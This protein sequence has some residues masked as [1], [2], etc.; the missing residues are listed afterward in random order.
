MPPAPSGRSARCSSI[1]RTRTRCATPDWPRW[2]GAAEMAPFALETVGLDLPATAATFGRRL[3]MAGLPVGPDRAARF[4]EALAVARPIA[5]RR[6]YW[7]ARSVFVSDQSQRTAFDAVFRDV[8]GASP[9]AGDPHADD[10]PSA[11]TRGED[12][13]PVELPAR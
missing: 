13:P 2:W 10:Q 8:F 7:I 4:A 11:V 9:T 1:A 3:R 5:R 6:L 12:S